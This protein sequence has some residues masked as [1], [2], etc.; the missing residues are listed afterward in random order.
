MIQRTEQLDAGEV[1]LDRQ[2][3]DQIAYLLAWLW[4][5]GAEM[6]PEFARGADWIRRCLAALTAE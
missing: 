1:R 5:S 2:M 3:A 4:A 6:P